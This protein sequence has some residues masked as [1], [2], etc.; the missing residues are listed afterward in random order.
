[1]L[2]EGEQLLRQ[3]AMDGVEVLADGQPDFAS[4]GAAR[5]AR[6]AAL[7]ALQ[8]E[9]T[10]AIARQQ[11]EL[12]QVRPNLKSLTRMVD[13]EL[14]VSATSAEAEAARK[15]SLDAEATFNDVKAQR[16]TCFKTCYEHLRTEI[17][18]IYRELT[19]YGDEPGGSAFLDLE[20][21]DEPYL[22]GVSYTTMVPSKRFR[23][24]H[25]QSGGER[26]VAALAL[27]FAL[28]SFQKP[29]FMILDEV[30]AP[31]DVQNVSALLEFLKKAEFQTIVISLKDKFYAESEA[32]VG[33]YKP[34]K[35]EASH[36]L[37]LDLTPYA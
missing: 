30:D 28:H 5:S 6:G 4:L 3:A 37:T 21:D 13:L 26:T 16:A 9:A 7:T 2:A 29:P 8:D 17:D 33:V 12:E 23:E 27:L 31:L 14:K 18:Q 34:F 25:L 19:A 32:L 35:S 10:R 15:A 11:T 36:V 1:M 20:D 22:K 24:L